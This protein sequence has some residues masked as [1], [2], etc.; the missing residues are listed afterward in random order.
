MGVFSGL[1]ATAIVMV[2]RNPLR[3]QCEGGA[4]NPLK[5][6]LSRQ[7]VGN[8]WMSGPGKKHHKVTD[9]KHTFPDEITGSSTEI[10]KTSKHNVQIN[11]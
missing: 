9:R 7:K 6:E 4:G 11:N 1:R 8:P 10:H 2:E 3:V 5:P